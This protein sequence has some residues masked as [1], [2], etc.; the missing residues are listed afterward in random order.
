MKRWMGIAVVL[1]LVAVP[2]AAAACGDDG[3]DEPE[4]APPATPVTYEG[5]IVEAL[6]DAGQFTTLIAAL[7]AAGLTDELRAEGPFTVF[8]PN[9]AAFDALP[10]G[11]RDAL[12]ADPTGDLTQLLLV[13]VVG[14]ELTREALEASGSFETLQGEKVFAIIG[15]D[16]ELYISNVKVIGEID[17]GNGIIYE[18]EGVLPAPKD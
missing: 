5:D 14:E 7:D 2:L 16:G 11:T 4:E 15:T 3:G 1:L 10:A 12:L 18:L 13:H 9:D 17:A 8:A 6:A